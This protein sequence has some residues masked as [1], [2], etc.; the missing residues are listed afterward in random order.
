MQADILGAGVAAAVA[1][2]AGHGLDGAGQEGAAQYI[3]RRRSAG[4]AFLGGLIEHE[5]V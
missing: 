3:D 1:V 4:A 2:E 5:A